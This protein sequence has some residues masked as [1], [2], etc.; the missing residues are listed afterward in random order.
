MKNATVITIILIV[1]FSCSLEAVTYQTSDIYGANNSSNMRPRAWADF[2]GDGDLDLANAGYYGIHIFQNEGAYNFQFNAITSHITSGYLVAGDF[3]GDGTIDLA[4]SQNQNPSTLTI[5]FNSGNMVFSAANVTTEASFRSITQMRSFDLDDDN[6]LD[7]LSVGANSKVYFYENDGNGNFTEQAIKTG[8][9]WSIDAGDFDGDGDNDIAVLES[10]QILYFLN[11]GNE[12]FTE[13]SLSFTGI[14]SMSTT[15]HLSAK[16]MDGDNDLDLIVT[17]G[18]FNGSGNPSDSY[19]LIFTNDGSANFT[20]NNVKIHTSVNDSDFISY[21]SISTADVTQDGDLDLIITSYRG[22]NTITIFENNNNDGTFTEFGFQTLFGVVPQIRL[23]SM[24]VTD[25][26]SSGNLEFTYGSDLGTAVVMLVPDINFPPSITEGSS[27]SVV[28]DEDGSPTSFSLTLNAT[29]PE[30]DTLTWSVHTQAASGS[31]SASGSGSSKSIAYTPNA[32]YNG[33]DN[34][35]IQVSDGTNSDLITVNVTINAQPDNAAPVITEGTSTSVVMDE[36]GSPTNFSLTLNASDAEN[37]T[38][39]WS[40]SSQAAAGNASVSGTGASKSIAYTPNGNYTGSDNFI[41]QVS[42]GTDTDLITVNV[43]INPINDTP[44]I[45]EGNSVAV[46]MDEDGSPTNFS[47]TLNASDAENDTLTWSVSSQAAAGNASVSGT[48]SSKSIAYT[49]AANYNGSDNFIVQVSD[50][51]DTDLITVNVTINPINDA[52]VIANGSTV[53]VTMDEDG[54][55]IDFSLTLSATDAD[56]D[57]LTWSV[58]SQAGFGMASVSGSGNSKSIA[59]TPNLDYNGSDNFIIQVSDSLES[60]VITVNVTLN[61]QA[62]FSSNAI[63]SDLDNLAVHFTLS[64]NDVLFEGGYFGQGNWDEANKTLSINF[65][66]GANVDTIRQ[67]LA[68]VA[69]A[70]ANFSFSNDIISYQ[71]QTAGTLTFNNNDDLASL[72]LTEIVTSDVALEFIDALSDA[73]VNGSY[74]LTTETV[75]FDLERTLEEISDL[76][77]SFSV[78]GNDL[79]FNDHFLGIGTWDSSQ[80]GELSLAFAS[81]ANTDAIQD[82]LDE[83]VAANANL[84]LFNDELLYNGTTMAVIVWSNNDALV[85]VTLDSAAGTAQIN[86]F[87]NTLAD[88]LINGSHDLSESETFFDIDGVKTSLDILSDHFE[89]NGGVV[90]YKG[91]HLGDGTWSSNSSTLQLDLSSGADANLMLQVLEDLINNNSEFTR[92]GDEIL[93]NGVSLGTVVIDDDEEVATVVLDSQASSDGFK[94][95]LDALNDTIENGDYNLSESM[96]AF[97][98][99]KIL[100]KGEELNTHFN[101]SNDDVLFQGKHLGRSSFNENEGQ[102]NIAFSNG[103]NATE[104]HQLLQD[105]ATASANFFLV[106][107]DIHNQNGEVATLTFS[108]NN[109][110]LSLDVSGNIKTNV[111]EEFLDTMLDVITNGDYTFTTSQLSFDSDALGDRAAGLS[112]YFALNNKEVLYDGKFL[113]QGDWD[114]D[115][116]RLRLSLDKKANAQSLRD[117]LEDLVAAH[118]DLSLFG[119][120]VLKNGE[121]IFT[122]VWSSNDSQ[123]DVTVDTQ[124][125]TS[126]LETLV[127]RLQNLLDTNTYTFTTSKTSFDDDA[128]QDQADVLSNNFAIDDS[129]VI[130]KGVN[131]GL[132]TWNEDEQQLSLD[133]STGGDADEFRRLLE[134]VV[135]AN[136]NLSLFEDEILF[137]GESIATLTF[138]ENDEGLEV[139]L[140]EKASTAII[141][142]FLETLADTI[143]NGDYKLSSSIVGFNIDN[144]LEDIDGL[145]ANFDINDGD[146]L[147]RGYKLGNGKFEVSTGILELDLSR[148]ASVNTIQNLLNEIDSSSANITI[149]ANQIFH[150][151]TSLGIYELSDDHLQLKSSKGTSTSMITELLDQLADVVTNGDFQLTTSKVSFSLDDTINDNSLTGEFAVASNTLFYRG[152]QVGQGNW[153][154]TTGILSIVLDDASDPEAFNDLIE[155]SIGDDPNLSMFNDEILFKGTSLGTLVWSS[156]KI[157][158]EFRFNTAATSEMVNALFAAI[159]ETSK[160]SNLEVVNIQAAAPSLSFSAIADQD[161]VVGVLST[162]PLNI[163][164]S[165]N[166]SRRFLLS[167]GPSW[168]SV[169]ESNLSL[170]GTPTLSSAGKSFVVKVVMEN[171]F[172]RLTQSFTLNVA[173]ATDVTTTPPVDDGSPFK[174]GTFALA[175]N[176]TYDGLALSGAL[177]EIL[178]QSSRFSDANGLTN[179]KLP[180][181]RNLSYV[182]DISAAGFLPTRVFVASG[183]STLSV[184]LKNVETSVTGKVTTLDNANSL[185]AKVMA[186]HPTAG[187]FEAE[188][189]LQHNYTLNLP[190]LDDG[191]SWLIGAS[192]SGYQAQETTLTSSIQT[193]TLDF[194]LSRK[195]SLFWKSYQNTSAGNLRLV[196]SAEPAFQLGDELNANLLDVDSHGLVIGTP[197]YDSTSASFTYILNLNVLLDSVTHLQLSFSATPN[198]AQTASVD[199][200]IALAQDQSGFHFYREI[201]T[202]LGTS[203]DF[204]GLEDDGAQQDRSGLSIPSFGVSSNVVGIRME[205]TESSSGNNTSTQNPIYQIDAFQLIDGN[206]EVVDN[207]DIREIYITF[208]YDP[209]LWNPALDI[210]VFRENA[211]APWQEHLRTNIVSIDSSLNTVT[212]K[213]NHLSQWTLTSSQSGVFGLSGSGSSSGGGCLLK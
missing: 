186:F 131:L 170:Q 207:G 19:V 172:T 138:T 176:V 43:T 192:Q 171:G 51:T 30:S 31:A 62:D 36:D 155:Q 156:D 42:D 125:S 204:I 101:I 17:G 5:Y 115:Q 205:R 140:S 47:L 52:P 124:A 161:A 35:I 85:E 119:D 58:S 195:T 157:N 29:D 129:E 11:D 185:G 49:P 209:T 6:D 76:G 61:P 22:G 46:I 73:L 70:S 88:T 3:N 104:I 33:S 158:F 64:G 99:D 77:V 103:V 199:L 13:F 202:V 96:I 145:G 139:D 81:G 94:A 118:A 211:N 37:D 28:M 179:F 72:A 163:V 48:G 1:L 132:G 44:T 117:A 168:L 26:Y 187:S 143:E 127:D 65:A 191:D 122:V 21:N 59:Y 121:T 93:Y 16:D 135:A 90:I 160:A 102:A 213:T 109:E 133:F 137:E 183:T 40:V 68:D 14:T 180:E 82:L 18:K 92:F 56:N 167:G 12:S 10:T 106:G 150:G 23:T 111:L 79:R 182:V 66:S 7:I 110:S 189:D 153:D 165:S 27:T 38:L 97:S 57:T 86:E 148:G 144:V 2:D 193:Q 53:S 203:E 146:V 169:N 107:D 75:S 8:Y 54:S 200:N 95:F 60:D 181:V 162:I 39:T 15:P 113:G 177:V 196:I 91:R 120:E 69:T 210:I 136:D 159:G 123:V 130:Y 208:Q 173:A 74:E 80:G 147:Y 32:D 55:P 100:T 154:I 190:L 84:T 24:L 212:L 25:L 45:T 194:N 201:D 142:E 134:D 20:Q 141:E 63:A 78:S 188:V 112:A 83:V 206:L 71:S 175:I 174:V 149:S 164:D 87:L 178:G 41:V 98:V 34:F 4:G 116:G 166:L 198:G 114:A 126:D 152:Y 105:I 108:D 184:G 151:N 197:S 89:A 9:Y 128:V 67:L 50:G